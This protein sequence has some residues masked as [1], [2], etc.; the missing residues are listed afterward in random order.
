MRQTETEL[1]V[2]FP[3]VPNTPAHAANLW[4]LKKSCLLKFLLT[5]MKLLNVKILLLKT[6]NGF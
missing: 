5:L 6:F 4:L 3:A 2:F 1:L